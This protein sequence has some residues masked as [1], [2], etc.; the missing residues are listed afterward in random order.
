MRLSRDRFTLSLT[1]RIPAMTPVSGLGCKRGEHGFSLIMTAVTFVVTLGMLGLAIEMGRMFIL[2][3]ELQAYADAA[4]MAAATRLDGTQT[5]I[6]DAESY[7]QSGP[8]TSVPNGAMM[9][10]QTVSNVVTAYGAT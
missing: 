3:N 8:L 4:A 2:K 10:T 9:Q 5:G 1:R 7:A 6:Q